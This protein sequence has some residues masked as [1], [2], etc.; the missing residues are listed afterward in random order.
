MASESTESLISTCHIYL[1]GGDSAPASPMS[2]GFFDVDPLARSVSP[3]PSNFGCYSR[4]R[5][6]STDST[7]FN[8]Q[9]LGFSPVLS[10]PSPT[11]DSVD[12]LIDRLAAL[13]GFP[14]P[15]TPTPMIIPQ[16]TIADDQT[17]R[18]SR[19]T[20]RSRVVRRSDAGENTPSDVGAVEAALQKLEGSKKAVKKRNFFP[21]FYVEPIRSDE[22]S[23]SLGFLSMPSP[24]PSPLIFARE[25]LWNQFGGEVFDVNGVEENSEE[26]EDV[27]REAA[28]ISAGISK[29][30]GYME[31]EA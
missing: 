18:R 19:W 21:N 16:S 27:T 22:V 28:E 1:T 3:A 7:A 11:A 10:N 5:P 17:S 20:L 23:L 29:N 30:W 15:I 31:D 25:G 6:T 8:F 13:H 4:S 14:D 26:L 24:S 2:S 12:L 9:P